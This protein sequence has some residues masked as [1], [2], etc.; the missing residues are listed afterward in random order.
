MMTKKRIEQSAKQIL[1]GLDLLEE[2]AGAPLRLAHELI[3]EAYNGG[4][5]PNDE[6]S[7]TPID[8]TIGVHSA[9]RFHEGNGPYACYWTPDAPKE[10]YIDLMCRHL[11]PRAFFPDSPVFHPESKLLHKWHALAYASI[12]VFL[13]HFQFLDVEDEGHAAVIKAL[14][15]GFKEPSLMPPK[16]E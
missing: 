12:L 7:F 15:A 4:C 14:R 2:E 16:E 3:D 8:V 11:F 5:P 10:V 13:D 9:L 6:E 1:I